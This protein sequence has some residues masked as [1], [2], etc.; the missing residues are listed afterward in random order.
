MHGTVWNIGIHGMTAGLALA[1][2]FLLTE[3]IGTVNRIT[4]AANVREGTMLSGLVAQTVNKNSALQA[5]IQQL[6][7]QMAQAQ[8]AAQATPNLMQTLQLAERQGGMSPVT[9]PG[10]V[11]SLSDGRSA[12]PG[13]PQSFML[14]HDQYVLHIIADLSAAG[15]SALA[16]NG[17]RYVS[18]SAIFCAGPTIRVNGVPYGSPFVIRA[19][20]NPQAMEHI[21]DQDPSIAGWSQLISIQYHTAATVKIPGFDQP[22]HL[23]LAKPAKMK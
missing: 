10:E 20:G 2:G 17:Q 12:Y 21:L 22:V 5:E 19:V 1:I 13:E 7:A 6:S 15:A 14:V 16:V 4:V 11:V 8:K 23:S 9:G 3:E 18:T